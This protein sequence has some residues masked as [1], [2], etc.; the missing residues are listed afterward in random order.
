M[1]GSYEDKA[2]IG[3]NPNTLGLP[4]SIDGEEAVLPDGNTE[5]CQGFILSD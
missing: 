3:R 1:K 5:G 4:A 2:R